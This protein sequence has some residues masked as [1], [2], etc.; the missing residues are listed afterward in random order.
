MILIELHHGLGHIL[1]R[2]LGEPVSPK[3]KATWDTLCLQITN[4]LHDRGC[5][6]EGFGWIAGGY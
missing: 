4:N 6:L 2:D 1:G 5:K 3:S